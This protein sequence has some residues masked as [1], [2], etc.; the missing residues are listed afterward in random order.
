MSHSRRQLAGAEF[1]II[2]FNVA[3]LGQLQQVVTLIH[4]HAQRVKRAHHFLRIRDNSLV[5]VRQLGQIV[6]LDDGIERELHFL[7]VN[8]HELHL[9]RMF[10]IE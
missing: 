2:F 8:Q 1:G 9:A 4:L 7:R 10:R 6:I 5:V 3:H